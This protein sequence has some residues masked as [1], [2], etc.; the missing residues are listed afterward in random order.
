MIPALLVLVK[1]RRTIWQRS[2]IHRAL[3]V[4]TSCLICWPWISSIALAGL[5]FTLPPDTVERGWAIPF[6]T[7][8]QIPLAVAALMLLHSYQRT[9]PA[10][11][12]PGSS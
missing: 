8:L 10:P 12:K 4:I 2:V 3:F 6:W 11:A 7:V 5:S 9:F 1:E